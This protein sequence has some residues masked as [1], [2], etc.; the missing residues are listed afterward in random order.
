MPT[1]NADTTKDKGKDLEYYK[2]YY[3]KEL[4]KN[5]IQRHDVRTLR[6]SIDWSLASCFGYEEDC[7]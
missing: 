5:E 1:Q 2:T 7:L 6:K 4:W 3:G